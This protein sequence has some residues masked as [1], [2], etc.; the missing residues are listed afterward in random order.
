[1]ATIIYFSFLPVLEATCKIVAF[2]LWH[3]CPKYIRV[4]MDLKLEYEKFYLAFLSWNFYSLSHK[5]FSLFT[6]YL[7]NVEWIDCFSFFSNVFHESMSWVLMNL[8]CTWGHALKGKE[9]WHGCQ[10]PCK[11]PPRA[12]CF[13]W[14]RRGGGRYKIGR[15]GSNNL[16]CAIARAFIL[17]ATLLH[18][19]VY[20]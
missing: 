14:G 11:L 2:D 6:F 18:M 13:M 16:K 5:G 4:K 9:T 3:H 1:M 15:W 17:R 12:N 19:L 10:Q 20:C 7:E 8:G